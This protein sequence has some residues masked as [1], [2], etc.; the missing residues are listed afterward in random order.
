MTCL[1]KLYPEKHCKFRGYL[2]TRFSF[3]E[4]VYY[5]KVYV[6]CFIGGNNLDTILSG[7][8]STMISNY[9]SLNVFTSPVGRKFAYSNSIS[10]GECISLCSANGFI[11]AGIIDN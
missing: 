8:T 4:Y 11:L 5:W 6:G 9:G 3:I 2:E 10:I 7:L 1:E